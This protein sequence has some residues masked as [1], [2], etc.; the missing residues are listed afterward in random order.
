[1]RYLKVRQARRFGLNLRRIGNG[2]DQSS[3]VKLMPCGGSLFPR[4]RLGITRSSH[5]PFNFLDSL[6]RGL[7]HGAKGADHLRNRRAHMG[8][9]HPDMGLLQGL[10]HFSCDQCLNQPD[11]V[12]GSGRINDGKT[13]SK[14]IKGARH[15][16]HRQFIDDGIVA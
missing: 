1:V 9:C 15:Y 14:I 10:C 6:Q 7:G 3:T 16:G 4:V 8:G 11:C 5:L 12:S 13:C 2:C